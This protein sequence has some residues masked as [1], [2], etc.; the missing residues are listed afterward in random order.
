VSTEVARI[1][2]VPIA[3]WISGERTIHATGA[4]WNGAMHYTPHFRI[5]GSVL[6]GAS[7]VIFHELLTRLASALGV[8]VP[9]SVVEE[10]RP[11][12]DRYG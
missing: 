9:A 6:Y 4:M 12:G 2:E 7:A 1:F 3:P 5:E 10:G 8:E 11:W